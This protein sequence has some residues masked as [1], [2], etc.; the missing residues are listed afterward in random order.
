MKTKFLKTKIAAMAAVMAMSAASSMTAMAAP[1]SPELDSIINPAAG[2]VPVTLEVRASYKVALPAEITMDYKTEGS[3]M[4]DEPV[5]TANYDVIVMGQ[6]PS[7]LAV[8]VK[9]SDVEMTVE[10]EDKAFTAENWMNFEA[11]KET[12]TQEF[13]ATSADVKENKEDSRHFD[14]VLEQKAEGIDA[15]NYNGVAGFKFKLVDASSISNGNEGYTEV[16]EVIEDGGGRNT[17]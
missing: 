17:F 15:G 16:I 14:C 11:N 1:R 4:K 3:I 2:E 5:F 8:S 10:G 6:V 13:F 7:D 9:G 12:K